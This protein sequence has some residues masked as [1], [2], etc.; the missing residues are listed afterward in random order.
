MYVCMYV[1]CSIHSSR[2][3]VNV[4]LH[5]KQRKVLLVACMACRMQC[6]RSLLYSATTQKKA[7]Q[8]KINK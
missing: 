1:Q 4:L 2:L 3:S 5:N 6:L 7:R 8:M